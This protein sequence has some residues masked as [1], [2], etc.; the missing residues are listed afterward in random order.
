MQMHD[1]SLRMICM[2]S[3]RRPTARRLHLAGR[4]RSA[5]TSHHGHRGLVQRRVVPWHWRV[6]DRLGSGL[7]IDLAK[8]GLKIIILIGRGTKKRQQQD[9]DQAV[10]LWDEPPRDLRRLQP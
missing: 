5:R 1:L 7:R 9:I 10:A 8:D 6:Q 2:V 3:Y 4:F